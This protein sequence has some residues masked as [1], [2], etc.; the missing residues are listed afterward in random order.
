MHGMHKTVSNNGWKNKIR[1]Q[2]IMDLGTSVFESDQRG[3]DRRRQQPAAARSGNYHSSKPSGSRNTGRYLRRSYG[4]F[5]AAQ[6]GCEPQIVSHAAANMR[7]GND[8]RSK[9]KSI[10]I[11]S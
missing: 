7:I 8:K 2:L 10:T 9:M 4:G 6:G 3:I 1:R 5:L 11:A